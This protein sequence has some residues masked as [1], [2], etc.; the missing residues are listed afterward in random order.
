[1]LLANMSE[2]VLGLDERFLLRAWNQAAERIYGWTAEEVMGK[3]ILRVLRTEYRGGTDSARLASLMEDGRIL[4]EMR[5]HRKD[6]TPVDVEGV[7][8]ALRDRGGRITGYVAVN[9]DVT[10]RKRGEEAQRRL[11]AQ[12]VQSDRLASMGTLAAGLA[13]EINNPLSYVVANLGYALAEVGDAGRAGRLPPLGELDAVLRDARDGAERVRAIVRDL[14][15]FSRADEVARTAVDVRRALE[16]TLSLARNEI[17]HR[18]RLAVDLGE[19]PL[20]DASPHRLGQVFLNLVIN[21]AQ[22]IPEGRATENE[23]RVAT[24][25]G[26]RGWAVVEVRDTGCGIPEA[27]LPR[28]FDPFFTTKPI[29]VGTG[30]GLAICHG[31]VTGLGGKIEV[32]SREGNGST[33]RV[34]LPPSSRAEVGAEE[35]PVAAGAAPGRILVVD[36]EPMV[37]RSVRRLLSPPHEVVSETEARGALARFERGEPYDLVLCDLMMPD[38]TGMDLHGEVLQRF[39][40]LARRFVFL[41]GGAFTE[42]ARRFLE[43]T[44]RPRLE[45][46]FAPEELR[47][48]VG[49]ALAGPECR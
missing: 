29:G 34:A 33:F 36:D 27:S 9:R 41:T 16:S 23:I 2:A 49:H 15:T 6:G 38:M 40:G 37:G 17:R 47:R 30:L 8:V 32:E 5:Q 21:A 1:M 35:E 7:S 22:A 24:H 13:H 11:Q 3:P 20:V 45:K 4:L 12:L 26:E 19:V 31:I 44:D 39:P 46:P 14:K 42:A 10:E 28:I 48:F 18:A 25:T 43:R